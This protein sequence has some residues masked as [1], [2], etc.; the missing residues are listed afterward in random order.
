MPR[1]RPPHHRP[2][3]AVPLTTQSTFPFLSSTASNPPLGFPKNTTPPAVASTPAHVLAFA[4]SGCGTS[5]TI[6]PVSILSARRNRCP[7]WSG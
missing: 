7:V 4:A 5:P 2:A 1:D 6:F 3:G